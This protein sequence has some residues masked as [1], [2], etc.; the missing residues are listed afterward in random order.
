MDG[1]GGG[2]E[3]DVTG[4]KEAARTARIRGA[5]FFRVLALN[6]FEFRLFERRF[7]LLKCLSHFS[8]FFI[9]K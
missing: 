5:C 3:S 1:W 2:A 7:S 4:R 8:L 9:K 6:C